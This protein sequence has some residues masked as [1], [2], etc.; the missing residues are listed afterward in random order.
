MCALMLLLAGAGCILAAVAMACAWLWHLRLRNAGVVDGVWV[1]LVGGLAILYALLGDGWPPRRA[2]IAFMMG[3]W[4]ARLSVHLLYDRVFGKPEDERYA[5]LRRRRGGRA[6]TWFFWFFEAQAIAALL[7]SWPALVAAVNPR[8]DFSTF[9]VAAA[10]LWIVA[11]TG[12][13]T[14]DRQLERFKSNPA[15]R[16][17]I[18]RAGLWRLSQHPN[19][20]FECLI[21]VA[22]ATYATGSPWG[23]TAWLCPAAIVVRGTRA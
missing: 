17:R 5:D 7:F 11:F 23:W 2:A 4:G 20:L 8:E 10:G 22:Y 9:E 13:V 19:Y 6:N 16:D 18:C 14:A 12:E 21:W 1:L 15:N 3:S